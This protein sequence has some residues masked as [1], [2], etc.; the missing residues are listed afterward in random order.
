MKKKKFLCGMMSV[1]MTVAL[2]SGC[3]SETKETNQESEPTQSVEEKTSEITVTFYDS[4]GTTVLKTEKIAQGSTVTEYTPSKDGYEFTGWFATPNLYH[5]FDFTAVRDADTSVFAGFTQHQDDTREFA[6]VGNGKSPILSASSW[7]N[8]INEEHKMVKTEGKNEYTITVD[9]AKGD[10]FQFAM[11]S[12][13]ENQRGYGYL[14]T[15]AV[16]G[17]EYFANS[18]SLGDSSVKRSN[19]KVAVDGNY[20]FILT[21]NPAEDQYET[22]NTNYTEDSKEKFNFN[23]YDKITWTYNGEMKTQAAAST[24]EYYIKGA[25]ITNW[26][27]V[28]TDRT[29]MQTENDMRTLSIFLKKG[30]EFLF[31]SLFVTADSSDVGT[32]YLR[33][34]NLDEASQACMDKTDSYNMVAKEDGMYTFTYDPATT[35]LTASCDNTQTLPSYEYYMK[36][37]F[38]GTNWGTEG[39]PDYQLVESEAGSMIYTLPV[40][41][42]AEGDEFGMESMSGEERILFYNYSSLMAAGDTNANAN[43]TSKDGVNSNIVVSVGGTYSVTYNAYTDSIYFTLVQ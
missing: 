15:I 26:G 12:S 27:D 32:E 25:G 1:L 41:E 2:A 42:L 18:G 28:Y 30:E 39:N 29:K 38:G 10:E 9:L 7:G 37:S 40:L 33:F 4:D 20:T 34:S 43:F 23:N 19:I 36:G 16:D 5:A 8:T 11:N 21:T 6:I 13:W 31:T 22:D 35:V 3:S 14:D 17:T 24:T